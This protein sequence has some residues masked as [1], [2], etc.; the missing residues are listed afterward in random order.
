MSSSQGYSDRLTPYENKGVLDLKHDP[1]HPLAV[2]YK[3][4]YIAQR[5]REAQHVVVHTGAGVST[6]SGI[7]DF[8]GPS[9]VWTV[10]QQRQDETSEHRAKRRRVS[11][12]SPDTA[13][14]NGKPTVSFENAMPSLT[15]AVIAALHRQKLIHYVISQNIDAL[16]L[17]SGLPRESLSELH[18]NLFV[19]WCA[20]CSTESARDSEATTVGLR[21]TGLACVECGKTLTDKALDWEDELP[22]P[23]FQRAQSH[24][25]KADLQLVVGTSCQMDPARNL[26]FRNGHG[27]HCRILVNLS[28]TP[29]DH[30]FGTVVRYDC[31]TVFAVIASELR[32][33]VPDVTRTA[34]LKLTVERGPDGVRCNVRQLWDGIWTC[35]KVYGVTS[36]QYA[37]AVDRNV[38]ASAWREPLCKA[39]YSDTV[40]LC[41]VVNVKMLINEMSAEVLKQIAVGTLPDSEVSVESEVVTGKLECSSVISTLMQALQNDARASGVDSVGKGDLVEQWFVS[42]ANSRGYSICVLCRGSVWSGKGMRERHIAKCKGKVHVMRNC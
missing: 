19:D 27:K 40:G 41:N 6:N 31:D 14:C 35:R 4:K 1:G 8:R 28:E 12:S 32:L 2:L 29:F 5:I 20:H 36:V 9:G 22:E 16:H 21:P 7:P 23:D 24:S 38:Q 42:K 26:P 3:A 39:G 34:R 18:G 13:R 33:A 30:R 37:S 17:K 25:A 11:A 10:Q 15:H